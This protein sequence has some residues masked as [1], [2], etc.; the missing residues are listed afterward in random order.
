MPRY[1]SKDESAELW[2]SIAKEEIGWPINKPYK[3]TPGSAPHMV[4]VSGLQFS[5]LLPYSIE[6]PKE[7]RVVKEDDSQAISVHIRHRVGV[8]EQILSISA[9]PWKK[10]KGIT[11]ELAKQ[12]K[13]QSIPDLKPGPFDCAEPKDA[14][15]GTDIALMNWDRKAPKVIKKLSRVLLDQIDFYQCF[16]QKPGGPRYC[17]LLGVDDGRMISI[18]LSCRGANS[19]LKDFEVGE[20][21]VRSFRK[22]R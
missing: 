4:I 16:W 21:I 7:F 10:N 13:L 11:E 6:I 18:M 19:Q 17:N 1:E 5:K 3:S 12:W 14:V 9:I 22:K 20:T 8:Y 15:L 2:Q